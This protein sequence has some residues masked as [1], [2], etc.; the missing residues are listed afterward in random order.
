MRF[1]HSVSISAKPS[2]VFLYLDDAEK[3]QLWTAGLEA[4][5]YDKPDVPRGVGTRFIQRIKEGRRTREYAGEV[6]G[7]GPPLRLGLRL[8]SRRFYFDI[9]YRMR[10]GA[11][12]TLVEQIAELTLTSRLA[13]VAVI[14]GAPFVQRGQKRMLARLKATV[15]QGLRRDSRV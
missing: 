2:E 13:R 14:L 11:G 9:D 8:T 7:Y 6:T 3:L 4:I 1:I 10:E 12:V 15:E 5:S